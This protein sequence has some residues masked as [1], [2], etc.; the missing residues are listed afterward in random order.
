MTGRGLRELGWALFSVL[1]SVLLSR[2][3]YCVVCILRES[4]TIVYAH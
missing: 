1:S 3:A 2:G 4:I